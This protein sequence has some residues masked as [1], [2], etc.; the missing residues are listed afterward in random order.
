MYLEVE[1]SKTT[2]EQKVYHLLLLILWTSH[3]AHPGGALA[4]P[5]FASRGCGWFLCSRWSGSHQPV[6][7]W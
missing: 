1:A 7:P 4:A 3:S 6:H 2:S 5:A